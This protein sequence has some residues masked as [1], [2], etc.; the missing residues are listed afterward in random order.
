MGYIGVFFV[1]FP[2]FIILA[3][4]VDDKYMSN[5][6]YRLSAI[7]IIMLSYILFVIFKKK[8]TNREAIFHEMNFV[9]SVSNGIKY[10]YNIKLDKEEQVS[11]IKVY[12]EDF[13]G[14]DFSLKFETAF[15][16]FFTSIGLSIECQTKD[17]KFDKNIYI[18][19]DDNM[20]CEIIK[21]S[22]KLREELGFIFWDSQ[23]KGIE[24]KKIEFY[25]GRMLIE[26]KII[27]DNMTE[28]QALQYCK[29]LLSTMQKVKENLPL[30]SKLLGQLYREKT[31]TMLFIFRA[32]M[33]GMIAN[34]IFGI[35]NFYDFPQMIHS[36]DLLPMISIVTVIVAL[37][38]A[39]IGL[40]IFRQ[41][42]RLPLFYRELL[43][44]GLIGIFL[45]SVVE[46]RDLNIY[47]DR[48]QAHIVKSV[49]KSKYTTKKKRSGTNYRMII[50]DEKEKYTLDVS[51][52]LYNN[53]NE[54]EKILIHKQDGFFGFEWISKM[55]SIDD[56]S[57]K[58]GVHFN[59]P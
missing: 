11:G 10:S 23:S 32:I 44:I 45:S 17:V 42:S 15:E 35:M 28:S 16:R 37:I 8:Y 21:N 7:P 41:S 43:I 27:I 36:F 22:S 20:L 31:S 51:Q 57:K 40:I 12:I 50:S 54:G 34:G 52:S 49:I 46:V 38:F 58:F 30:K 48:H 33:I 19:S 6:I 39:L 53:F 3:I 5:P 4:F 24:I 55:E 2:I 29:V 9:H 25:D 1:A 14:Y 47:L 26:G 18:V 56:R 13:R 59:T